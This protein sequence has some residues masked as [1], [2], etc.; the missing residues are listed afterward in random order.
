[1]P[2]A[3]ASTIAAEASTAARARNLELAEKFDRAVVSSRPA[4]LSLEGTDRWMTD[5]FEPEVFQLGHFTVGCTVAT[6][7]KR[8]NPLCLLNPY[9]F[10]ATF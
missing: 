2:G 3:D 7:L 8:K 9:V 1:M 4:R 6:A 10:W 5:I